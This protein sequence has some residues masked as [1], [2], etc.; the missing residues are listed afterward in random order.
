MAAL[1]ALPRRGI[2]VVSRL[3]G[4]TLGYYGMVD[5]KPEGLAAGLKS[6]F[7]TQAK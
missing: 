3:D 2:W 1:D 4:E 5:A 6:A 7:D